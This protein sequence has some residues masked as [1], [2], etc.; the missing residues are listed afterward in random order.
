[1]LRFKMKP[2]IEQ[3]CGFTSCFFEPLFVVF[4]IIFNI[5]LF[6]IIYKD[7]KKTIFNCQK[8]LRYLLMGML[9]G[10][11]NNLASRVNI[12]IVH[13]LRLPDITSFNIICQLSSYLSNYFSVLTECFMLGADFILI[14]LLFPPNSQ[15]DDIY[16]NF[17]GNVGNKI[18]LKLHSRIKESAQKSEETNYHAINKESMS[19]IEKMNITTNCILLKQRKNLKRQHIN[20]IIK[21]LTKK[22]IYKTI[23]QVEKFIVILF[24]FV[25]LYLLSF[26]L[27]T[28][29]FK[30]FKL[31]K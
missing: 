17:L 20:K 23:L 19:Q 22:D 29:G 30:G 7:D 25:W 27:W 26:I 8:P 4:G 13:L 11:I 1:M 28:H 21:S 9:I 18:N 14:F 10:D 3:K 12:Y 6:I 24:G 5:L 31:G 15:C 2:L 16:T